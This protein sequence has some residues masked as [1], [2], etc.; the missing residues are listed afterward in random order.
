MKKYLVLILGVTLFACT[1]KQTGFNINVKLNG[2]EGKILLE[3]RGSG[4][5]IPVDTADIVDGVAV[6]QGE[7][8]AHLGVDID[9]G[10]FVEALL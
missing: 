6:L 9:R 7:Q 2:A 10:L 4:A 5:W 8:I 3:Q 1:Q